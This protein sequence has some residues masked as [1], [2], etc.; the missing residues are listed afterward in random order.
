MGGG[1]FGGGAY[2]GARNLGGGGFSGGAGGLNRN[3]GGGLGGGY[4][5]GGLGGAGLGAGG[6]GAGGLGG[7]G[8]DRGLGGGLGAGAGGLGG[9]LGGGLGGLD[10][11]G[12]GGGLGAGGLEGGLDRGNLGGGLGGFNGGG[13]SD[14]NRGGLGGAFTPG[15]FNAPSRNDLGNFL[16]LPSDEGFH[17]LGGGAGVSNAFDVNHGTYDGPRGGTASGT[18]ITGP[19]G[20][21]YGRGAAEGPNGG[22]VAGRGVEGAG[23][24]AA[25]QGIAVGPDG[26]VAAG[27]GVR[28][29]DGGV[30]G[31]GVA[32][33]PDGGIA[34]GRGAIGPNG[35]AAGQ[36][37]V[38]GPGGRVA[39]GSAIRGPDGYGAA[40][41]F[42]AGPYGAAA[43]FARVTP[44]S[45]YVTAAAVRTNWGG[46]GWFRP[47]WYGAHP[48][49]W[50]AAGWAAGAAWTACTWPM[51]G[52]WFGYTATAP[53]YYDYGNNVVYQDDSVYINGQDMG[54]TSDYYANAGTI[55][56]AGAQAEA[57][58][59]EDWLPLGVFALVPQ[60]QQQAQ[61]AVQL[62]V[63]KQGVVRG[64]YSDSTTGQTLPVKGAVD[65]TSQ[66]VDF[67][68][69]DN[70]S[71]IFET[72]LYNL[73]K[74]EAPLLVMTDG[75]TSQQWLLVRLKDDGQPATGGDAAL[76][77]GPAAD[78][79]P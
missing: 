48:G 54:S 43:G 19:G 55:A 18:T 29:P 64:N 40:R 26:G 47:G 13:L 69:G 66:R 15:S 60:G 10:R 77:N 63:N 6:L 16:G 72:G 32:V 39:G 41:G 57:P 65:E 58:T 4:G 2:G 75:Q 30:A 23:G 12:L 59:S 52:D 35:G 68:I 8:F 61:R 28:G 42:A 74:D 67:T 17:G 46:Y 78:E 25:G 62:A 50:Y 11:G 51:M 38:A 9:E 56:G 44:S 53:V 1:G 45:R 24:A 27:G 3:L 70:T 22:V 21:T 73:T 7:G 71:T 20:N 5:A 33:G 79:S 36:G 31:R 34:A 37:I 49:A 14:I 76:N